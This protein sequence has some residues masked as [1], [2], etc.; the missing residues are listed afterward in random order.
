MA[1]VHWWNGL[2][3]EID[4]LLYT[5]GWWNVNKYIYVFDKLFDNSVCKGLMVLMLEL[6]NVLYVYI[7]VWSIMVIDLL[8]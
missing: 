4:I 5:F 2:K 1:W 7:V 3:M 8:L 6:Q